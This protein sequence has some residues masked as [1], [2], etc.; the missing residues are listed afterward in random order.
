METAMEPRVIKTEQEHEAAL[1]EI[2]ALAALDPKPGTPDGDRLELLA[3][4]V[5]TYEKERFPVERPDPVSAIR[6]RM[7]QQ[8]LS[9]ADLVPF[10]G[11]RSKVSEVLAGKRPLSLA[12]IRALHDGLGIPAHVLIGSVEDKASSDDLPDWAS[13]PLKLMV[14]RGWLS[15]T[16]QDVRDRPDL[17]VET[18]VRSAFELAATA[19]VYK[20]SIHERARQNSDAASL[21]AWTA[22]VLH[23]AS[24]FKTESFNRAAMDDAFLTKIARLSASPTG[25]VL[26]RQLL[27]FN[28]IALVFEP[29]LQGT[30]VD[31]CSL[32][33]QDGRPAIGMTI[34]YDRIDNF[35]FTLL[36][37]LGHVMRHLSRERPIFVDD[38]DDEGAGD[39]L[40]I[41]ADLLASEALI[42]R[43][44]W[45]RSKAFREPSAGAIQE[46][47][48]QLSIHP[49]IPAGR[50]RRETKKWTIFPDMLGQGEVSA[51]LKL[52]KQKGSDHDEGI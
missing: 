30:Y 19:P 42:P 10:L 8:G 44:I 52:P 32:L 25:P 31:G 28:G 11:S 18:Y 46:L 23:L 29:S 40:E 14:R 49:A 7:E 34:R 48:A 4:L 15:A 12:M 16:K 6:F 39:P 13:F 37:E 35:W 1:R 51:L 26:A 41:E 45:R 47:A 21:I 24:A 22:R 27:A 38:L 50:I 33:L 5:E 3:T 9:Q 36:H 43:S 2:E 17:A 20:R